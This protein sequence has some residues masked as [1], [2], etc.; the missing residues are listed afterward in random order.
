[1]SGRRTVWGSFIVMVLAL[2]ACSNSPETTTS[3]Q[4]A[5]ATTSSTTTTSTTTTTSKTTTT[6]PPTTTTT[7]SGETVGDPAALAALVTQIN[8]DFIGY[9]GEIPIPDLTNPDPL[10]ALEDLLGFGL[11]TSQ[12]KTSSSWYQ[13]HY[14]VDGPAFERDAGA[15][16]NAQANNWVLKAEGDI[17]IAD[18]ELVDLTHPALAGFSKGE[19]PL[20]SVAMTYRSALPA[21]T[22]TDSDDDSVVLESPKQPLELSIIVL[23]PTDTG[24]KIFYDTELADA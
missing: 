18:L 6:T 17:E 2:S 8:T 20:G 9:E 10:V 4:A 23:T 11:W 1:M 16:L 3:Q 5:P 22:V 19:I 14:V 7:V 24:W 15:A 21:F 13:I 12:A